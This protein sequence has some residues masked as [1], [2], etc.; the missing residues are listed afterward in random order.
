[1]FLNNLDYQVV[2]GRGA[3]SGPHSARGLRAPAKFGRRRLRT[4]RGLGKCQNTPL[5]VSE[6][7]ERLKQVVSRFPRA[8][9][10]SNRLF[11][12]FRGLGSLYPANFAGLRRGP[13]GS[14]KGCMCVKERLSII[15]LINKGSKRKPHTRTAVCFVLY[16]SFNVMMAM[17]ARIM[18]I[19]QKRTTIFDSGTMLKG[20]WMMASMPAL[21]G[22]WKW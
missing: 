18:P 1:M 3:P 5:E 6:A 16:R 8:R 2:I 19:N 10:G 13:E 17:A 4:L 11:E 20:F 7:S 12:G 22:F 15:L 14:E 9:K 21:P